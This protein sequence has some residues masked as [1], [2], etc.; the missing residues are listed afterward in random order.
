[1]EEEQGALF[2]EEVLAPHLGEVLVAAVAL[3]AVALAAAVPV[4]VGKTNSS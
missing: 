1:M 2:M 3:A 4:V